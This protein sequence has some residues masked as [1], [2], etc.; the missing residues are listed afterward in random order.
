MLQLRRRRVGEA[1]PSVADAATPAHTTPSTVGNSQIGR[2]SKGT[3][4]HT[5][6]QTGLC[7]R[8]HGSTDPFIVLIPRDSVMLRGISAASAT[9]LTRNAADNK[10][11][12]R[13]S[14][15]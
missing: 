11:K 5:C 12:V 1:A 7:A 4:T 10:V 14:I 6:N 13:P 9:A 2:D 15:R 3:S 8:S